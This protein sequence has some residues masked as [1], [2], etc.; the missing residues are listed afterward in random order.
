MIKSKKIDSTFIKFMIVGLINTLVGS[1]IMFAAY[2]L[3]G[4]SYWAAS[5]AN[6]L[7]GSIVS[8]FLNKYYTFNYHKKSVMVVIKFIL[9]ISVCYLIAYGLAKPL[10]KLILSGTSTNIRDNVAM[11]M[12]MIL[13]TLLNYFSQKKLTFNA[14]DY[15]ER[16]Y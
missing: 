6:Y 14:D 3:G 11:L 1:V 5:A 2:N 10:V 8:Y 16:N 9:N 15:G 4:W 13:F 7:V 12:G